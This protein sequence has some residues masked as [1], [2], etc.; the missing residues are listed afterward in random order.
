MFSCT[1]HATGSNSSLFRNA[2]SS[3]DLHN[4]LAGLKMEVTSRTSEISTQNQSVVVKT[5]TVISQ[6]ASTNG[7]TTNGDVETQNLQQNASENVNSTTLEREIRS[8]TET[9]TTL[10]TITLP[11]NVEISVADLANLEVT[12]TTV[13]TEK[14]KAP[15][16]RPEEVGS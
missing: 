4:R 5:T 6:Q 12:T 7:I 9:T 8:G 14:S 10:A 13:T 11:P 15:L 1:G 16:A 3:E 2:T